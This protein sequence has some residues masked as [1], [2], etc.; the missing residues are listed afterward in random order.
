MGST[1]IVHA[2]SH[3]PAASVTILHP[4]LPFITLLQVS[5]SLYFSLSLSLSLMHQSPSSSSLSLSL[6][7]SVSV[8]LCLCLSLSRSLISGSVGLCIS[9]PPWIGHTDSKTKITR[10]ESPTSIL[11]CPCTNP[12]NCTCIRIFRNQ[13]MFLLLLLL[14]TN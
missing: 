3:A 7:L 1:F 11:T 2:V 13:R 4:N 6:S 9:H 10:S 5:L 14:K 8:C 12:Q